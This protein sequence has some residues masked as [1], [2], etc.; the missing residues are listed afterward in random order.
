[1]QLQAMYEIKI[2]GLED[3]LKPLVG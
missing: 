3:L 2:N 1:M